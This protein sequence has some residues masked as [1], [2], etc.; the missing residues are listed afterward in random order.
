MFDGYRAIFFA[1][2][3]GERHFDP[4]NRKPHGRGL[5]MTL[6]VEGSA[7][8]RCRIP[9]STFRAEVWRSCRAGSEERDNQP[10]A[11]SDLG[12]HSDEEPPVVEATIVV[13][14]FLALARM[15]QV[16]TPKPGP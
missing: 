9:A 2:Y 10:N 6:A 1:H 14:D 16:V 13:S 3:L 5:T 8:E 7:N 12:M 11:A 4:S 15:A